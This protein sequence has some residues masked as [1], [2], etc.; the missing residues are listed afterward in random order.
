MACPKVSRAWLCFRSPVRHLKKP[1]SPNLKPRLCTP[2]PEHELDGRNMRKNMNKNVK[3]WDRMENTVQTLQ[4]WLFRPW[5]AVTYRYVQ[6]CT[7]MYRLYDYKSRRLQLLFKAYQDILKTGNDRTHHDFPEALGRTKVLHGSTIYSTC[8]TFV[9]QKQYSKT[10]VFQWAS[11]CV[12]HLGALS[13]H[14]HAWMDHDR[15]WPHVKFGM[16]LRLAIMSVDFSN[17]PLL[18][19]RLVFCLETA[20][21]FQEHIINTDPMWTHIRKCWDMP[22]CYYHLC[23][24]SL[25][26]LPAFVIV[27]HGNQQT[28]CAVQYETVTLLRVARVPNWVKHQITPS[29][30]STFSTEVHQQFPLISTEWR[31]PKQIRPSISRLVHLLQWSWV[32]KPFWCTEWHD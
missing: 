28:T 1:Q 18:H 9:V 30:I 23:S 32:S 17:S 31:Q 7:D 21:V 12:A 14:Y 5:T 11:I 25:V 19:A 27:L 24:M 22:G 3:E 26:F 13:C 4:N 2:L 29:D 10:K 15:S 8:G 16:S 6:T 20:K